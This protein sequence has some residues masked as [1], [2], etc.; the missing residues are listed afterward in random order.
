VEIWIFI[1]WQN[2]DWQS[3]LMLQLLS[4]Y[5]WLV[6]LADYHMGSAISRATINT[7][8]L[9]AERGKQ[10][11]Q[12]CFIVLSLNDKAKKTTEVLLQVFLM[13][14]RN[15]AAF[16]CQVTFLSLEKHRGRPTIIGIRHW[17]GLGQ[18]GLLWG[19]SFCQ[20]VNGCGLQHCNSRGAGMGKDGHMGRGAS[21][22]QKVTASGE[23]SNQ[24][25]LLDSLLGSGG[26]SVG[27]G[28]H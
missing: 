3:W 26:C 2:G 8:A 17:I 20:E 13:E 24:V 11:N 25:R 18:C 16:L 27:I 23:C 1:T 7:I 4:K 12:L 19:L 22:W 5:L 28:R 9:V 6:N 21:V 10:K 15:Y 14:A